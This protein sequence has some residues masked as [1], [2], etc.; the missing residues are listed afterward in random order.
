MVSGTG[1]ALNP[2]EIEDFMV[3]PLNPHCMKDDNRTMQVERDLTFEL[4]DS[5][6]RVHGS[7]MPLFGPLDLG[8]EWVPT[9]HVSHFLD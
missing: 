2:F 6:T 1:S 4:N 7:K 5:Q 3:R 8:I 9:F